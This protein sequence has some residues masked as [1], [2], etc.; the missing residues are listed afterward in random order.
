MN[1]SK[2]STVKTISFMIIFSIAV[3]L[4]YFFVRTRTSPLFTKS[5]D[6]PTELETL[7]SK[8]IPNSYPPSPREVVKLYSRMTKVLYSEKL[9][10][11]QIEKLAGQLKCLYDDELIA[12]KSE[13]DYILDLKVEI[14]D[15]RDND[16]TIMQYVI[17]DSDSVVYWDKDDMNYASLVASFTTKEGRSYSKIF[18][19]FTLRKDIEGKWKILGWT[20]SD[21]TEISGGE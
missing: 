3:I 6:S 12:N 1:K 2:K 19:K 11:D 5:D 4:F 13:T 18:E 17:D 8:D 14:S 20:L 9:Q 10:D 21:K 7:L 15:Y 16:R